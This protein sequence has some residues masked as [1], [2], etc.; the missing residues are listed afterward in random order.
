M[1]ATLAV[2]RIA[3]P[4]QSLV[5]HEVSWGQYITISDAFVDRHN[6]RMIY[7]DGSMTFLTT[8]R[9]H[10][11]YADCLGDL[12]KAVAVCC[13]ILLEGSGQAT[14]RRDDLQGGIEGDRTYY[15]GDHA[16]LMRGSRNIDLSTQPPP[17]LAIEVEVSH[18]ADRALATWGRLGVPEV[19]R[20]NPVSW[21]AGFWRR[22]ADGM[23]APIENSIGLP[24]LTPADV[25]DQMRLADEL[26][27]SGW[28]V[29]LGD[30]VRDVL[31]P[32]LDGGA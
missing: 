22:Q 13:G 24:A 26:G 9:R 5:L 8:S 23:Y 1:S 2:P 32:R 28:Y 17:D 27:W 25:L 18:P 29:Q 19:W 16:V 21:H 14:Y 3:D 15:F 10:D 31:V 7:L 6:P 20:I 12:V 4:D 30:W 11:W